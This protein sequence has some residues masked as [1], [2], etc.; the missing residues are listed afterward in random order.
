[1]IDKGLEGP[2]ADKIGTFVLQKGAPR[3]MY[4]TLMGSGK[5]GSHKGASEALEDMRILFEYLDA[6]GKLDSISFDMS[7]A[8]GLDYYTGVIY[9]AVSVSGDTQVG[10]IGGGGRYDN[11]V[12]MFQ[13]AGKQVPCVGVSIGIERVFTLMESRIRAQQGGSLKHGTVTVLVA[14]I[15]ENMMAERMKLAKLLWD[16]NISAEY[17]Q[18]ENPKLAKEITHALDREVPF[19]A[20]IGEEE[21]KEG[22]CK[23][24]DLKAREEVLVAMEDVVSTLIERGAIPVGCEFAAEM[25]K[26]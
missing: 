24:K 13:G 22:K 8:R 1:M 23:I 15:G 7:L 14:S 12:G 9:E 21:L 17:S 3:E 6:M 5:F 25:R 19:M 2:V 18:Q 10:S 16:G 20:I 26:T 4:N 11:L